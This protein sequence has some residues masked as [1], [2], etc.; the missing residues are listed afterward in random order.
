MGLVKQIL[1]DLR[2]FTGIQLA[3]YPLYFGGLAAQ[4]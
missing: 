1:R 2:S 4:M 3:D